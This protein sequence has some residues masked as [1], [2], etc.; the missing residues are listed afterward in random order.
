MVR[1]SASLIVCITGASREIF[2]DI[3]SVESPRMAES[4][5]GVD[6]EMDTTG[7]DVVLKV[8]THRQVG[9][10]WDLM[11]DIKDKA[12]DALNAPI[13]TLNWMRNSLNYDILRQTL[14]DVVWVRLRT[15]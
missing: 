13:I 1:I 9:D 14:S 6:L 2:G 5:G 11:P 8:V 7:I 4:D 10:D 12:F 3:G 15:A